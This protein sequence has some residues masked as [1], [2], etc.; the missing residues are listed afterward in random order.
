MTATIAAAAAIRSDRDIEGG[1]TVSRMAA[2]FSSR[3]LGSEASIRYAGTPQATTA[4][5]GNAPGASAAEIVERRELAAAERF[6][7]RGQAA[8][9]VDPAADFRRI[10]AHHQARAGAGRHQR[11]PGVVI[12]GRRVEPEYGSPGHAHMVMRNEPGEQGAGG[13][14]GPIDDQA[15]A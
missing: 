5:R 10:K 14:A 9:P 13:E 2:L 11:A 4:P 12:I 15:L 3:V 8:M 6:D 7:L 1:A